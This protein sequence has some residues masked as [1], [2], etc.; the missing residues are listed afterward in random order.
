MLEQLVHPFIETMQRGAEMR[1]LLDDGKLL[2]VEVV[3][4]A[5]MTCLTLGV[6]QVTRDIVF[7][8]IDH[9]SGPDDEGDEEPCT[10]N[11]NSEHLSETCTTLVLSTTH[12]LT[13]SFETKQLREYFEV[14][15]RSVLASQRNV[16]MNSDA[17]L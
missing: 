16:A 3:F 7:A 14:C 15:M 4:D 10:V 8:E 9:I 2:D 1:V 11:T 13:F 6:K 12:F 17:G 5:E